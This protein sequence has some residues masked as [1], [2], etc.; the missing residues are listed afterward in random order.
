MPNDMS[1]LDTAVG[2]GMSG[3]TDGTAERSVV[4][5]RRDP[6]QEVLAIA[7]RREHDWSRELG[8][9]WRRAAPRFAPVASSEA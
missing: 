2:F 4:L 7:E 8:A 3:H 9:P 1:A 5:Q 6:Q